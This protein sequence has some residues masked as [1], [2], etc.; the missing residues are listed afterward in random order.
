LIVSAV[1]LLLVL[2]VT[3]V[4]GLDAAYNFRGGDVCVDSR[5]I[6]SF[7]LSLLGKSVS[8]I[9]LALLA[10]GFALLFLLILDQWDFA[11]TSMRYS[12]PNACKRRIG[13][14]DYLIPIASCKAYGAVP[15]R[16]NLTLRRPNLM[17]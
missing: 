5:G 1:S 17:L 9:A 2:K 14:L 11:T 3:V 15:K 7:Y 6:E 8:L 12:K 16:A 10:A 13:H 4:S